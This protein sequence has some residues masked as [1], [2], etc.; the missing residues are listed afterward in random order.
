MRID[1]FF[2]QMLACRV[3]CSLAIVLHFASNVHFLEADMYD[4]AIYIYNPELTYTLIQ[5]APYPLH[6]VWI[7]LMIWTEFNVNA[8]AVRETAWRLDIS[9][10][11]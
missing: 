6:T 11:L 10:E 9:L 2:G 5:V 4:D 3:H 8:L 1:F 7:T